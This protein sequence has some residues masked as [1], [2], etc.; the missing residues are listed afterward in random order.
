LQIGRD[1]RLNG[2]QRVSPTALIAWRAIFPVAIRCPTGESP[3]HGPISAESDNRIVGGNPAA[4]STVSRRPG[5]PAGT[6]LIR[7]AH[8]RSGP[9]AGEKSHRAGHLAR[10]QRRLDAFCPNGAPRTALRQSRRRRKPLAPTSP[11]WPKPAPPPP[12]AAGCR[13]RGRCI[14]STICRGT[15]RIAPS[16]AR[17]RACCG[18]MA[19]DDGHFAIAKLL[20]N[21][22]KL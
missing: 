9:G 21:T 1:L 10:L 12:S 15:R 16:R 22:I 6:H 13:P 4:G 2:S 19:N 7:S 5:G 14:G 18:R 20:T 17:C 3:G 8:P 11:A